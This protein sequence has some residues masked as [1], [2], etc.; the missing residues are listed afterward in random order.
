MQLN[1]YIY[2]IYQISPT[3]F[4]TN[5]NILRV[6]SCHLLKLSAYCNVVTL[7]TKHKII[8][9]N[10]VKPIHDIPYAL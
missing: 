9:Y 5:C 8:V 3:C 2:I 10:V 1:T 7:V 6:N 4:G